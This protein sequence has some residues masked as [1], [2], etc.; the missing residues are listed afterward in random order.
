ML[1]QGNIYN[2]LTKVEDICPTVIGISC[3]VTSGRA[4]EP[5]APDSLESHP[6]AASPLSHTV[7]QP[8]PLPAEAC[9]LE[10]ASL[11]PPEPTFTRL[12]VVNSK[13][14]QSH[15]D[16]S[17]S[18]LPP[19]AKRAKGKRR[20]PAPSTEVDINTLKGLLDSASLHISDVIV[21]SN[22]AALHFLGPS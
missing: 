2:V 7:K 14:A 19:V 3:G 4:E 13:P 15:K 17:S 9:L 11:Q 6:P 18:H 20:P 12:N 1:E 22:F 21:L 5:P 10:S 16:N 8:L